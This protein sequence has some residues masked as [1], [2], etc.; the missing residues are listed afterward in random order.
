MWTEAK[1]MKQKQLGFQIDRI[2]IRG[3]R[4]I[5]S[6]DLKLREINILI[7]ANG[8]GKSN[9]LSVFSMMEHMFAKRLQKYVAYNGGPDSLL[10][11]GRQETEKIGVGLYFGKNG[12]G[13]DLQPTK[14]NRLMFENEWMSLDLKKE[15]QSL[16]SGHMESLCESG[17]GAFI[18]KCALKHVHQWIVYHFRDTSD[19]ARIKQINAIND[20]MVL[21]AD[22][23]NLAA[24]LY[25]MKQKI[26]NNYQRIRKIVQ[27]AAPFFDDFILRPTP[28]NP[29]MIEL[30]WSSTRGS[31]PF[32]AATLSDGT[33]R[34]ICL[35]TL[36]LQPVENNHE[37]VLLEEPELGLHPYA[38]YLLASLIKSASIVKQIII[39]TQSAIL[40]SEF[41]P[42]DIIIVYWLEDAS[43]LRRLEDDED[44]ENWMCQDY[45]LG[46][47]WE[48]NVFGGRPQ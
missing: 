35:A 24:C 33:L 29:D 34:F 16:G 3:F 42:K 19:N 40:L 5:R 2:T 11:Y 17:A 8:A 44:L 18:D 14:D 26:P 36:L 45:S 32:K 23:G 9:F 7:G 37:M 46:E 20:N 41:E 38:L 15:P 30:A 1:H 22:G 27:L 13:F 39:S 28:E 43:T 21:R 48:K 47:L 4:S 25:L 6:C 12:Y 10:W 31:M